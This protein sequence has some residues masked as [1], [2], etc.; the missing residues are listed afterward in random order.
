MTTK[1]KLKHAAA[2]AFLLSLTVC[3]G[4]MAAGFVSS[5]YGE[6]FPSLMELGR[7]F[8]FSFITFFTARTAYDIYKK[9]RKKKQ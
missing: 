9:Y 3:Y 7:V 6:P 2:D 1:E 4:M 8:C 5:M